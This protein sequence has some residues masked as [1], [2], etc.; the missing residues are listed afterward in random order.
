MTATYG[1]SPLVVI[2][3]DK[4][5]KDGTNKGLFNLRSGLTK[6]LRVLMDLRR[7]PMSY[8]L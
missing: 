1:T 8:A 4:E 7:R 6:S 2:I 3:E 5:V